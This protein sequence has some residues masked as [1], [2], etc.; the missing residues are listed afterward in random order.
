M[1]TF[2][3]AVLMEF[4]ILQIRMDLDLIDHGNRLAGL[5]QNLQVVDVKVCYSD[6]LDLP[7]S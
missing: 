2:L 4:A 1:N 3:L 7:S 6:S 5:F